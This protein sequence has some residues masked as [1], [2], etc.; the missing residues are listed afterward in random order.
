M[1]RSVVGAAA[2]Q[3]RVFAVDFCEVFNFIKYAQFP[4]G[5]FLHRKRAR[6]GCVRALNFCVDSRGN[7]EDDTTFTL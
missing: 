7:M 2:A 4:N 1:T 5:A 6:R 3:S